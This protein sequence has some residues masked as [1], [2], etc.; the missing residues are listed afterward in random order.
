[1]TGMYHPRSQIFFGMWLP[2]LLQRRKTKAAARTILAWRPERITL[3]HGR[4]FESNASEVLRR[5][6]AWA[7]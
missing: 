4:C 1:M 5:V 2:M 6:F 3:T 7:L